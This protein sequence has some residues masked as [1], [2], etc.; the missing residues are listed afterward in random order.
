MNPGQGNLNYDNRMQI[1]ELY[2]ENFAHFLQLNPSTEDLLQFMKNSPSI[3]AKIAVK[4]V[5]LGKSKT[6][7]D[8]FNAISPE[9]LPISKNYFA[10]ID[11][12]YKESLP[13]LL[14]LQPN[15]ED[16]LKFRDKYPDFGTNALLAKTFIP[17]VKTTNDYFELLYANAIS[18]SPEF[19][20]A[21]AD[22]YEKTVLEFMAL[23]PNVEEIKQFKQHLRTTA[24]LT[25]VM[26]QALPHVKSKEDFF[27]ILN[28]EV[29]SPSPAYLQEIEKVVQETDTPFLKPK[30]TWE[31]VKEVT[32]EG[33]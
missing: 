24:A 9:V 27:E 23:H 30:P 11:Q 12:L 21:L 15:V 20:K 5:L 31:E 28:P 18:S 6:P 8:F 32:Q 19:V 25:T 3:D 1:G 33:R 14:E 17:R 2:M 16:F 29:A 22:V 13:H 10:A 26:R 7:A 4:K